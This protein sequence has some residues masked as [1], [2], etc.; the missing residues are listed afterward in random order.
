[1]SE[2]LLIKWDHTLLNLEIYLNECDVALTDLSEEKGF[3]VLN[4]LDG[5]YRINDE[6]SAYFYKVEWDIAEDDT[7]RISWV[8]AK[9][10]TAARAMK[11]YVEIKMRDNDWLGA[12]VDLDNALVVEED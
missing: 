10:M 1:M 6:F 12:N 5:K 3:V 7:E 4:I 11:A 9:R 2:E 8:S